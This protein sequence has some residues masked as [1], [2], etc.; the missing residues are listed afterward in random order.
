MADLR[1][2]KFE[3]KNFKGIEGASFNWED[4][5]VLIG[6]NNA[7]KSS[8]LQ[9]LDLF[10]RGSQVKDR[11]LFRN[12][13]AD[14]DHAI[15]LVGHFDQLSDQD[16]TAQAIR[17]RIWEDQWVLKKRFWFEIDKE[18]PDRDGEWKESYYSY[19]AA[20]IFDGWPEPDNAWSGF[21]EP[22]QPL[23]EQIED[24]GTRPNEQKREALRELVREH[25]PDLVKLDEPGWKP[26]PGGGG[27]WKSNANSIVPR[28]IFVRAVH[29]ASDEAVSKDAST[30]GKI[31]DLIVERKLMQRPEVKQLEKQ[32]EEVLSLFR[33]DPAH[34]ERQAQE[35]KD[36]QD[37]INSR[38][39]DVI[40][41]IA[42]ID[43][44]DPDI[45]PILLPS[46]TLLIRDSDEGIDTPVTHQ[47][48]GLQRTLIVALLQIYEEHL[49]EQRQSEES[50]SEDEYE[51]RPAILAI[52]EPELYMHPQMQRK[53]RD[54][55][56][57][58][59]TQE[60]LQVICTTHSPVFLDM[61]QPHKSIVRVNKDEARMVT[62][63]Q[64]EDDVFS[65][66]DPAEEK[67]R[68]RVL[69]YFHPT[70][71]EVFFAKRV[72]L[73]EEPGAI[74]AIERAAVLHGLFN[75]HP[76]ARRDCALIDCL[77]KD[78]IPL[79]QRV[80]NHFGIRYTV[81]YDEDPG[82]AD[83]QSTTQKISDELGSNSCY[84]LRPDLEGALGYTPS[85]SAKWYQAVKKVEELHE[86]GELPDEFRRAMNWV[87]FGQDSE[88]SPG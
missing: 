4:F 13:E 30:Y 14:G 66:E 42:T 88:P 48:H 86:A 60:R 16:Q 81:I 63:S 5:I 46:T 25:N 27:N 26:N 10:L 52:E 28:F 32:M 21:P 87:Y 3:I 34:P 59:A 7:G 43:T 1:L 80:L 35:I 73:F 79:F 12:N 23:I 31:V 75:S 49:N 50:D 38:L 64:A 54:T 36:L 78:Q 39:S 33:P 85:G 44:Q 61:A 22:Y 47:G 9:A 40:G 51:A 6:E 72:V 68:L 2:H 19:S 67:D 8:A 57:R 65:P 15:E 69:A 20:E 84:V 77:G 53:M 62:F 74:A 55:L 24:R 41:G 37:R 83:S 82:N 71:N 11:N 29:D 70:V 58:L 56:Y 76:H 18:K 45:R 17:G